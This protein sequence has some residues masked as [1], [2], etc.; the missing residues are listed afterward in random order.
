MEPSPQLHGALQTV[1]LAL[2]H[3][4]FWTDVRDLLIVRSIN[5]GR[6]VGGGRLPSGL[7][8]LLV[9]LVLLVVLVVLV[10]EGRGRETGYVS[11]QVLIGSN[12]QKKGLMGSNVAHK[13]APTARDEKKKSSPGLILGETL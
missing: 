8:L 10:V 12:L 5:A 2:Q 7:R 13:S 9:L 1:V 4:S 11:G 3:S 6:L